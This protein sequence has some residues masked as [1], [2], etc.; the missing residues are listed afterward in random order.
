LAEASPQTPPGELTVLPQTP[1]AVFRGLL[2]KGGEEGARTLPRETNKSRHLCNLA[3]VYSTS[4]LSTTTMAD[5]VSAMLSTVFG[6]PYAQM[7]L[8]HRHMW[9]FILFT[10]QTLIHDSFDI[11]AL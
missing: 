1:L 2:L 4:C 9:K 10:A 5:M 3:L 11:T 7:C 8:L 6:R